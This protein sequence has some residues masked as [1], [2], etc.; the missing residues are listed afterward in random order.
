MPEYKFLCQKLNYQTTRVP[1]KMQ[2]SALILGSVFSFPFLLL[3]YYLSYLLRTS[4]A[5]G[6]DMNFKGNYHLAVSSKV[7]RN[8]QQYLFEC[9]V[10][11]AENIFA[12]KSQSVPSKRI[13]Y[14]KGQ[15]VTERR[16]GINPSKL[17]RLTCLKGN[18]SLRT[19]ILFA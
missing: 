9:F 2:S 15:I 3:L 18:L 5:F 10:F 6:I 8:L 17:R 4:D 16:N 11:G 7:Y 12:S 19:L 14:K 13:F 1:V